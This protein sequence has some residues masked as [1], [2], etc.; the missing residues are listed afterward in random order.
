MVTYDD[1]LTCHN[2]Y[3]HKLSK[4][5]LL[6]HALYQMLKM[7]YNFKQVIWGVVKNMR[8]TGQVVFICL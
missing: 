2:T 6:Q 7:E 8:I 5:L 1:M 3:D 4:Q